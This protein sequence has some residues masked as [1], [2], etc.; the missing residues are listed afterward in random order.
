MLLCLLSNEDLLRILT[1][2]HR[3]P[4]SSLIEY[5][6]SIAHTLANSYQARPVVISDMIRKYFYEFLNF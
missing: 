6:A 2:Y 5:L 1:T 3:E 4:P